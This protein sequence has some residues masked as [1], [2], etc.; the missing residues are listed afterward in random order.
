MAVTE[1][2]ISFDGNVFSIVILILAVAFALFIIYS[3]LRN[4]N[5]GKKR[6]NLI[7]KFRKDPVIR[8]G[9]PVLVQGKVWA[10]DILLPT[11][12]EQVAFYALFIMSRETTVSGISSEPVSG[13]LTMKTT[14][15]TGLHGFRFF[16][17]SGDFNLNAN[18]A[19]YSVSITSL[20]DLFS[21]GA[22]AVSSLVSGTATSH[23]VAANI[24]DDTA[25]FSAAKG[26]LSWAFGFSAPLQDSKYSRGNQYSR[27]TYSRISA[28]AVK[29]T[30]D[31]RVQDYMAGVN[32]P[33]G[34]LAILARKGITL[35][36]KEELVVIELFIPAG[37][38]V[39][40]FGTL[41][42]SNTIA[43]G[44]PVTRLSVSYDDPEAL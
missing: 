9:A 13:S 8:I 28:G 19:Q 5:D 27:T 31:S 32:V 11:T 34:I 22:S 30:V 24:I 42:E 7:R 17:S 18:G 16:V 20:L 15:V 38:D 2:T 33:E 36:E 35:E 23:G 37:K 14:H 40:V 39:Y 3:I 12:G 29:S 44:D 43:Y 6:K 26:A 4:R 1:T 41:C 10:R 25:L 21:K